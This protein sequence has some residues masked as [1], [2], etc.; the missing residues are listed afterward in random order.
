MA[1]IMLTIADVD[2]LG[3]VEVRV[4]MSEQFPKS[5]LLMTT[6]QQIA[7]ELIAQ[8]QNLAKQNNDSKNQHLIT[9]D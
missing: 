1:T 3:N 6:A 2:K 8:L 5:A 4:D 9:V 7:N